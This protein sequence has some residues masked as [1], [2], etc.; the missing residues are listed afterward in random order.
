MAEGPINPVEEELTFLQN[1][2]FGP[3]EGLTSSKV[4]RTFHGLIQEEEKSRI[5]EFWD[6]LKHYNS[7]ITEKASRRLYAATKQTQEQNQDSH[8]ENRDP[9]AGGW[10]AFRELFS[11]R[12]VGTPAKN[13]NEAELREWLVNKF[14]TAEKRTCIKTKTPGGGAEIIQDL[15]DDFQDLNVLL[16]DLTESEWCSNKR[17]HKYVT[18]LASKCVFAPAVSGGGKTKQAF[19]MAKLRFCLYFDFNGGPAKIPQKDV[20]EFLHV[21]KEIDTHFK[22]R[23][24]TPDLLA[25]IFE[26]VIQGL[27]LGRLFLLHR[28]QACTPEEFLH[29]QVIPADAHLLKD[30]FWIAFSLDNGTQKSLADM[31]LRQHKFFAAVDEAQNLLRE[32]YSHWFCSSKDSEERRPLGSAV[33]RTLEDNGI[34]SFVSGTNT[35]VVS[36][37]QLVSGAGGDPTYCLEY[38]FLDDGHPDY[39][40][41]DGPGGGGGDIQLVPS[42]I[43]KYI[44]FFFDKMQVSDDA[45]AAAGFLKGRPRLVA[46]VVSNLLKQPK[47]DA[48]A[49]RHA[50]E[51][52]VQH[53]LTLTEGNASLRACW[54][55]LCSQHPTKAPTILVKFV[56][57]GEAISLAQADVDLLSSGVAML[58]KDSNDKALVCEPVT[59][60]AALFCFAASEKLRNEAREML[61]NVMN[62]VKDAPTR[63]KLAEFLIA[64]RLFENP[65]VFYELSKNDTRFTHK[66]RGILVDIH[67]EGKVLEQLLTDPQNARDY[68][69]CM[70]ENHA[71]PDIVY[72]CHCISSKFSNGEVSIDESKKSIKTTDL[73]QAY[74]NANGDP[75]VCKSGATHAYKRKHDA[76]QTAIKKKPKFSYSRIRIE[77]P[78]ATYTP[79]DDKTL[80]FP[81]ENC[82]EPDTL[83]IYGV[84]LKDSSAFCPVPVRT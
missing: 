78:K 71:G 6:D 70:P 42:G 37:Q 3:V 14:P 34:H 13:L 22:G 35:R 73:K 16:A 79:T 4:F 7:G 33:V 61:V 49:F 65:S 50:V 58:A 62:V 30:L 74:T 38:D 57:S 10:T 11:G 21:L 80:I 66:P 82:K 48:V 12:F 17:A 18:K 51:K 5:Q 31:L 28:F 20:I 39:S 2:G 46:Q 40:D 24:E 8:I 75:Y 83:A 72:P 9:N 69:I 76:I 59:K 60:S 55:R 44:R 26:R 43:Y 53:N 32:D 27:V 25:V 56:M 15:G 29:L 41:D 63:G 23:C 19:D 54:E 77:Y 45:I 47:V 36:F 84:Q 52:Q 67:L 1:G 81:R 68:D 64:F